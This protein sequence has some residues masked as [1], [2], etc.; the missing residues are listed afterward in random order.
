[1]ITVFTAI[2]RKMNIIQPWGQFLQQR[3]G[4]VRHISLPGVEAELQRRTVERQSLD[5][6]PGFAQDFDAIAIVISIA[7]LQIQ[8]NAGAFE[9]PERRLEDLS[10]AGDSFILIR[11]RPTVDDE[12]CDAGPAT[13]IQP[14]EIGRLNLVVSPSPAVAAT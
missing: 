10:G 7:V 2:I 14:V 11:A 3:F 4:V 12:L 9:L 6:F 1:M 13:K 8:G 5:Q